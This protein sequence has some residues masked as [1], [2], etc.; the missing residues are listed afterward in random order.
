MHTLTLL[1]FIT[2]ASLTFAED[3]IS[4]LEFETFD[5]HKINKYL[6]WADWN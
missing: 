2:I 4:S 5:W 3:E 6:S 1:A